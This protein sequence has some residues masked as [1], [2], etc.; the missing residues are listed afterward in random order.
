MKSD[1]NTLFG[2]IDD[3]DNKIDW[4][5]DSIINKCKFIEVLSIIEELDEKNSIM[6]E[7]QK[8]LEIIKEPRKD[9]FG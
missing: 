1:N 6:Q 5:K 7:I 3:Y 9:N 2:F 8:I 4:K